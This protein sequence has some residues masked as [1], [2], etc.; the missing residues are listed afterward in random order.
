MRHAHAQQRRRVGGDAELAQCRRREGR[1][2][3]DRPVG[4]T[5]PAQRMEIDLTRAKA[6]TGML[7]SATGGNPLNYGACDRHARNKSS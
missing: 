3:D 7:W 2:A 4:G 6:G 1:D 5:P